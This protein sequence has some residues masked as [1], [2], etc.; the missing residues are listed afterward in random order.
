MALKKNSMTPCLK[1][2]GGKKRSTR[3]MH[4]YF[5]NVTTLQQPSYNE[6]IFKS[7]VIM[8]A[9]KYPI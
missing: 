6:T 9:F 3:I 7:L 1:R 5:N 2:T 4:T 8:C